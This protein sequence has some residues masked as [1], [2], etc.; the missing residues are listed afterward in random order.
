MLRSGSDF[1]FLNLRNLREA[2]VATYAFEAWMNSDL[3]QQ[4]DPPSNY[5]WCKQTRAAR[6]VCTAA[7]SMVTCPCRRQ[8]VLSVLFS[9]WQN[10]GAFVK[11][12][13]KFQESALFLLITVAWRKIKATQ[14]MS[15]SGLNVVVFCVFVFCFFS[16]REKSAAIDFRDEFWRV[17]AKCV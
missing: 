2:F 13:R 3:I 16:R 10:F 4:L 7:T 8:S 1:S 6:G 17:A 5:R 15:A 12:Q 14:W 11:V 9:R